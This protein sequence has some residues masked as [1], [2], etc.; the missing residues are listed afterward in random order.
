MKKEGFKWEPEQQEAFDTLKERM[1]S[2]PVLSHP[3]YDKEFILYTNA[4][5][6]G[7]RYILAQVKEDG[8]EHLIQYDGKKLKPAERNYTI[9]EL[10]CLG[11]VWKLRKNNQFL[12]QNKFTFIT[13]HKA[14]ETL[15][16]QELSPIGRRTRWILELE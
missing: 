8:K 5:Y 15:R 9:T 7:L 4:S 3:D 2:A 1:Y 11:V 6:I 12:G 13:D 14:L 16:R 10:E